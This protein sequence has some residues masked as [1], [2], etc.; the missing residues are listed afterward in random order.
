MRKFALDN[1]EIDAI[2]ANFDGLIAGE[3]AIQAK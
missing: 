1:E 2:V 3:R